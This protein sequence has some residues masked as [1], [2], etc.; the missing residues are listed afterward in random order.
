MS[1][2]NSEDDQFI[3]A[4]KVLKQTQ[5]RLSGVQWSTGL[6]DSDRDSWFSTKLLE[7]IK[8]AEFIK[9]NPVNHK[10]IKELT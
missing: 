7:V 4:L 3:G 5:R 8:Q 10:D 6:P 2:I 1:Y 9:D